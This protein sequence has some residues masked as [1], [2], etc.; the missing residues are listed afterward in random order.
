MEFSEIIEID[1]KKQFR[2]MKAMA[3][4][5]PCLHCHGEKAL[6]DV[7]KNYLAY[8]LRIKPEAIN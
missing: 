1:G 6:P 8:T 4:S 5:Q 2:Y 3:I 7:E